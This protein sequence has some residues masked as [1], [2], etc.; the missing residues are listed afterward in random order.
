[1]G[2]IC[3]PDDLLRFFAGKAHLSLELELF[4]LAVLFLWVHNQTLIN[5]SCGCCADQRHVSGAGQP[6]P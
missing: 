6:Y 5:Y 2:L 1:M 3:L 4:E